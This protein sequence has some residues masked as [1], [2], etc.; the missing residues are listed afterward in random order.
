MQPITQRRLL[1]VEGDDDAGVF[2][3]LLGWLGLAGV[4]VIAIRGASK[5]KTAIAAAAS[6]PLATLGLVRDADDSRQSAFRS[7][8]SALRNAGL[9]VPRTVEVFTAAKAGWPRVGALIL[10]PTPVGTNRALEDM[11]FESI[12]SPHVEAEVAAYV[13]FFE[14]QGLEL[15]E[16][17]LTKARIHAYL[18]AQQAPGLTIAEAAERGLWNYEHPVFGPVLAF[19]RGLA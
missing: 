9:P 17:D 2:R 12:R 3:S 19:L 14:E 15:R 6:Y 18:A 7:L 16:L 1:I 4:Q 5:F 11:L 10:P 8:Q 13:T